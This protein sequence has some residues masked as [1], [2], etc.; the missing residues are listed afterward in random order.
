MGNQEK[1]A[2]LGMGIIAKKVLHRQGQKPGDEAFIDFL[3]Y[4]S[5]RLNKG[6]SVQAIWRDFQERAQ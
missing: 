4:C 6:D 2:C 1:F 5:E 3:R